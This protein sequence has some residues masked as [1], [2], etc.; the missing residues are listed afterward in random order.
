VSERFTRK[1]VSR[2]LGLPES[3]LAYWERLRLVRPR[4][5]WGERFYHFGDLVVLKTIQNLA[6]QNVPVRRLHRA[7]LAME[8][9]Y[10]AIRGPLSSLRVL[11]HGRQ[12]VIQPPGPRSAPINPLNGQLLL[13]Y[14]RAE[15]NVATIQGRSA[16]EWFEVGLANDGRRETLD[17]AIEAYRHATRL[18]P[19]WV[20]AHINLGA[21]LYQ[22]SDLEGARV[23]FET[24]VALAEGNA[25]A[26]FN[27]GCVLDDLDRSDDAI[28]HFERTIAM[29]GT[30]SDA[31]FNLAL[32]LEKKGQ[33]RRA[34]EHWEAYLRFEPRG[35]WSDF[36]RNKLSPPKRPEPPIPF[37]RRKPS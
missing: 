35:L 10:G 20:A 32:A 36:A 15:E 37:P 1:E 2:I 8:A 11:N 5:R 18:A 13:P 19:T 4:A 28:R 21:A 6:K 25:T 3:Q 16:E 24:A 14:P 29:D 12:V 33:G 22:A 17:L 30:H 27:L 34:R 26:H 7:L 23:A 31:H 9:R